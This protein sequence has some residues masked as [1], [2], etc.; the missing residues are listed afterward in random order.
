[1]SGQTSKPLIFSDP[2]YPLKLAPSKFPSCT[3]APEKST[4]WKYAPDQSSSSNRLATD[5]PLSTDRT[6]R[7]NATNASAE[8][9]SSSGPKHPDD[10]SKDDSRVLSDRTEKWLAI[11]Q[12][13]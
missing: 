7:A 3:R 2:A 13:A 8:N 5:P 10:G 11:R 1:M 4:L 9:W 6:P 12:H